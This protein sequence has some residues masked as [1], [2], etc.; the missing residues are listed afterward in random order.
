MKESLVFIDEGF[1]DK[2]T[3]LFGD[4]TRIKFDKLEFARKIAKKEGFFCKH[5]FYYTCPPYQSSSPSEEEVKRKKGYDKFISALSKNKEITI[6]EGRVQK[7][8]DEFRNKSYRQKGLDTLLTIDLSHIIGDYPEITEIILVSSDT[9]FCPIITDIRSR[10]KI[11]VILY[12]YFDRKRK[13]KFSL[14]NELI[15][16]CSKY[17]KL[18]KEDFTSCPIKKEKPK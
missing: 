3:K 12:T 14:S 5:L 9:D 11:E 16:C 1:L 8:I 13:S 15:K 17:R 18:T 6:R 2:L 4:G 10:N 7:I